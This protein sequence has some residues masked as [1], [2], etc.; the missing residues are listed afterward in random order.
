MAPAQRPQSRGGGRFVTRA[1][2]ATAAILLSGH[3]WAACQTR[4][5]PYPA[6]PEPTVA[7]TLSVDQA[8]QIVA[9]RTEP[10]TQWLGPT[11]GPKATTQP[12]TIAWVSGDESYAT[13]IG[14]G[15]GVRAAGKALGWKVLTFDGRGT[16]SGQL[17]AMQQALA[18]GVGA[19]IT[20]ADAN[21]LQKPIQ[22]AVKSCIPVIGI[23]ATA[24]PGPAPQ[25]GLY[26]NIAS[27]PAE[28]GESQAAYVIAMSDGTARDIHMVDNSFAIARFKARAATEPIINCKGCKFLEMVNVPI[29]DLAQRVAPETSGLL[30]RYGSSWWMTTCCDDYYPYVAASLR[31]AGVPFDKVQLVGA[32]AP[33]ATYALIRKGEYE[34]AS[35][36]EPSTL[37]GYEAVDAIVRAMAGQPPAKWVQPTFIRTKANIDQEGGKDNALVPSNNFSCH[38]LNIWKGTDNPCS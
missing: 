33:P 14:W 19:I 34:V 32:D 5:D 24:F 8:K 6:W 13:Y 10:Q 15:N 12:V 29:G 21:A 35:V 2:V 36:P 38:Y 31:A 16:V 1:V 23:H 17:A 18:A 28:I 22:A 37:F 4:A 25:L 26:D 9:D 7:S 27:S 3:A 11:S 20:H 30:A